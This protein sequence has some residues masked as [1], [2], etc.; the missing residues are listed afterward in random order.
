MAAKREC[1]CVYVCF[2]RSICLDI[3]HER[4]HPCVHRTSCRAMET[5]RS[6]GPSLNVYVF[7]A[8]LAVELPIFYGKT[9]IFHCKNFA[10]G[11]KRQALHTIIMAS[12]YRKR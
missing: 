6:Y 7:M 3:S 9:G 2:F 4:F 10:G 8:V 12:L 11:G 1:E 5:S